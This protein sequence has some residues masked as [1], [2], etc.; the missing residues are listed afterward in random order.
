MSRLRS[1]KLLVKRDAYCGDKTCTYECEHSRMF[2]DGAYCTLFD[3][4]LRL[5]RDSS[6]TCERC[7]EC[8]EAENR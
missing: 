5:T 4:T 7:E 3:V 2:L 1:I 8:I 6:D